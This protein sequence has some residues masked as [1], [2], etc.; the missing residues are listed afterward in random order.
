MD[1]NT[2]STDRAD[3]LGSLVA[4]NHELAAKDLDGL[5]EVALAEDTLR[6]ERLLNSLHGQWLRRLATVDAQGAA[7]ADQDQQA[8][9]TASW[10]RNRL[11]LSV[12]AA[13]ST[14]RTGRALFRGPFTDTAAALVAGDISAAHARVVADGTQRLAEH[15]KLDA[16]PILA[17]AARRLDPPRLRQATAYLCQVA[18][19]DGADRQAARRHGRRGLWLSATWAGMVAVAGV[20]EPEAGDLVQ[21]ALEPLA[22]PHDGRDDRSGGQR[23]AD[24]LTELARRALE[25]G[26]LPRVGGVRPQLLVT[27]D[28]DS[29]QGWPGRPGW[30]GRVGGAAGPGGVPATGLRRDTDPGAGQPPAQHRP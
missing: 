3:R 13:R 5:S 10:L 16:D 22:R 11:R 28:L 26:G 1:S 29:L 30:G 9:S 24:A 14:V 8:L 25:G 20:L 17:E 18:D 12:G 6:L 15:R 7:G 21:A 23:T 2:H 27:V 19:P 4:A